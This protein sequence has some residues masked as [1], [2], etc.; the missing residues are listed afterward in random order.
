MK[1]NLLLRIGAMVLFSAAVLAAVVQFVERDSPDAAGVEA[2]FEVMGVTPGSL[3]AGE[4]NLERLADGVQARLADYAGKVVFL[5]FWA[6]WCPPCVEEMPSMQ[7][8]QD[9]FADSGLS[10][11]A[12]NVGE[13]RD[14]V[15]SFVDMLELEYDILLDRDLRVTHEYNVR[16]LPTTLIID[17]SGRI[18][19]TKVGFH[20][21][22]DPRT[23][24]AFRTVLEG[25]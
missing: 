24:E 25:T 22:D 10:V 9:T 20:H 1:L 6:T 14:H 12:V 21:W 5:N 8:L 16:G 2:A 13:E 7:V 18:I 15:A 11:V 4:L 19:G 17:R 3:N 23:L